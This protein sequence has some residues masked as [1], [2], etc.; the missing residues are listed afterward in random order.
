MRV[1]LYGSVHKGIRSLLFATV[2][3]VARA[4]FARED[5]AASALD[6]VE[7]LFLLLEEHAEHEDRVVMPVLRRL[8]AEVY[9]ALED[10]HARTH[11]Q[12][13]ELEKLASR[14]REARGDGRLEERVALGRRLHARLCVLVAEH[15]RHMD[16]EEAEAN[17]VLW[18]HL[19]DAELWALHE[20]IVREI[21]PPRMADALSVMLPAMSLPE[22][23]ALVGSLHA[24]VPATVFVQLTGPARDALGADGWAATAAAAGI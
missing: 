4:D 2:G 20:Q 11:G 1:D 16:R 8:S 7:R 17:R 6:A 19:T 15:L 24:N 21:P 14:L 3:K 9:T 18:A 13:A 10:E 5:E 23:A 12:Q 22:R